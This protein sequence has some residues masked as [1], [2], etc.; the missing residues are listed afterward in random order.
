MNDKDLDQAIRQFML[1][2]LPNSLGPNNP[3]TR[4]DLEKFA[5]AVVDLIKKLR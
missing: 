5:K 1:D 3:V 4:A 2:A